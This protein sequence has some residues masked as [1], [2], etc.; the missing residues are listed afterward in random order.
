MRVTASWRDFTIQHDRNYGYSREKLLS[1]TSCGRSN[2]TE[3]VVEFGETEGGDH[4]NS[5]RDCRGI[6]GGHHLAS[7]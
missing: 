2:I 7:H 6:S 4:E 5:I 1:S 3:S